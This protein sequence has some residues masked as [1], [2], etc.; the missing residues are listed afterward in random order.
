V[1]IG[2]NESHFTSFW[3]DRLVV[4][5]IYRMWTVYTTHSTTEKCELP[6]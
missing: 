2:L 4:N 5:H 6:E 3:S 1:V